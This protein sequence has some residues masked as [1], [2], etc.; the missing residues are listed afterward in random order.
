M[1]V[2]IMENMQLKA[3]KR[4]EFK[5]EINGN[6]KEVYKLIQDNTTIIWSVNKQFGVMIIDDDVELLENWDM[7]DSIMQEMEIY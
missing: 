5:R 3:L 1:E 6:G 4:W 7:L 2:M